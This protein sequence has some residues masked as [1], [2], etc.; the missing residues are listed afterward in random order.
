MWKARF[1]FARR[2]CVLVVAAASAWCPFGSS[3]A[4]AQQTGADLSWVPDRAFVAAVV[5]I[6]PVLEHRDA[7]LFPMEVISAWSHRDLGLDPLAID[8]VLLVA[9][10]GGG[11]RPE[12]IPE[13]GI[14]IRLTK[15]Y[16]LEDILPVLRDQTAEGQLDGK[17]ARRA[18]FP[19]PSYLMADDRTVLV[20]HEPLL[21]AMLEN[22]RQ[23]KPGE[24]VQLMQQTPAEAD[25]R[26]W[27]LVEPL[28]PILAQVLRSG[29]LPPQ[30]M[31][32]AQTVISS[33]KSLTAEYSVVGKPVARL[34]VTAIDER[35]AQQLERMITELISQAREQFLTEI[36]AEFEGSDELQQA[37]GKYVQRLFDYVVNLVRPQRNKDRLVVDVFRGEGTPQMGPVTTGILV[38]LLLPAVQSAR[39]AARRMQCAN[40]L[41]RIGLAMHM[42]HDQHRRLPAMASRDSQGRPLLSWRVHLLPY[43]DQ[44]ELYQQFRLDEPWDSDHNRQLI[45]RMPDVY[46]CPSAPVPPHMTVYQVPVAPGTMFGN[47]AGTTFAE[48]VDGTS[49]TLMIVERAPAKAVIWTKPEDWEVDFNNP[50]EE[51]IG[52]HPRGFNACFADGSVRFIEQQTAQLLRAW[53]TI[54]GGEVVP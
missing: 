2:L 38:G 45:A 31:P 23:P 33:I 42:Y 4:A 37:W 6:A 20:G 35:R 47:P 19:M 5:R 28:R 36:A 7:Q 43:L 12:P 11:D 10:L 53:L 34:T 46:R 26:L 9:T 14:V 40:N 3:W 48:V 49:N 29:E 32:V 44:L 16:R 1:A 8:H 54:A 18:P 51:L 27:V 39:E 22:H 30:L 24:L 50:L 52:D 25:V 41:K 15:P 21:R 17:P 13:I